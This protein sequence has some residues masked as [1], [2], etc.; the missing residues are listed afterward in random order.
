MIDTQKISC[1]HVDFD[2]TL[3]NSLPMMKKS[4]FDFID[5]YRLDSASIKFSDLNGPTLK[6]ITKVIKEQGGLKEKTNDLYQHYLSIVLKNYESVK[7]NKGVKKF[8]NSAAAE[9]IQINLVTS[10]ITEIVIPWLKKQNLFQHIHHITHGNLRIP[11]KPSPAPYLYSLSK[12]K[13]PAKTSIAIE[14]SYQGALSATTAGLKT[15]CLKTPELESALKHSPLSPIVLINS[16]DDIVF[17][18]VTM[19]IK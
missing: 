8:L 14:D 10:S 1:I 18:S 16:F 19:D 5:F 12:S 13:H 17:A 4:F 15:Y 3:A 6:E 9:N 7:P 2:G 11:A